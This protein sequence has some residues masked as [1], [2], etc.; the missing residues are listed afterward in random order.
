MSSRVNPLHRESIPHLENGFKDIEVIL[1]FLPNSSLIMARHP[2]LLNA[3]QQLAVAALSPGKIDRTLK[4]LVGH[5]ASRAAGCGYCIAHTGHTLEVMGLSE[6]KFQEIWNFET[7]KNFSAADRAALRVAMGAAQVPNG[8]TDDQFLDLKKYFD[9]DQIV[10]LLGVISLYGFLNR[11]NDT[12]ATELEKS[13]L[14]FAKVHLSAAGIDYQKHL[15][16]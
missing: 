1:G 13:P 14:H 6:E 16:T 9:E 12:L 4:L 3:F 15:G 11:W 8:V 2:E 5:M 7:D 10:E